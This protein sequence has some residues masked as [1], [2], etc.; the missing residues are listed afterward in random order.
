M[1]K[2]MEII[3]FSTSVTSHLYS[4]YF[5]TCTKMGT[6]IAAICAVMA[7]MSITFTNA[8]EPIP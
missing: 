3:T 1:I 8:L 5:M 7:T 4:P 6:A 2:R